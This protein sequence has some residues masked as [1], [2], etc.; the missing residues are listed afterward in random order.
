MTSEIEEI[1]GNNENKTQI[2]SGG[3]LQA[4]GFLFAGDLH[5]YSRAPSRRK[6]DYME[7]GLD[8]VHQLVEIANSRR[9][10][11]VL[12]G[13]VFHVFHEPSEALKTRLLRIL[14]QCWTTVL[15]NVGNHDMKGFLLSDSDTL[16]VL[17]ESG[18]PLKVFRHGGSG[19]EFMLDGVRVGLGF[20]PYGQ[21]IPH[22]VQDVFP[23]AD[24]VVWVSH[25]DVGFEGSYPGAIE[26]FEINGCSLLVNGHMH[27]EKEPLQVGD[28]LWCNFGSIMRTAVDAVNHEPC[29]W[30]FSPNKGLERIAL[31]YKI[32]AFDLTGRQVEQASPGDISLASAVGNSVFVDLLKVKNQR[33]TTPTLD[34]TRLLEAIH[35]KMELMKARPEVRDMAVDLYQRCL[36][37]RIYGKEI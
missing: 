37:L 8:K 5:L 23:Q 26:P 34:S 36:Q 21:E 28:T 18:D 13:D 19:A 31:K 12:T 7:A 11:L 22:S 25:H 29:A 16:A 30:S 24:G 3:L 14:R 33:A 17:A 15:S 2:S 1:P 4:D 20:T 32:N 9:L 10:V 35:E 27:L 6:S